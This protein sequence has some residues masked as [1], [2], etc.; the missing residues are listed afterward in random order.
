MLNYPN[1][2]FGEAKGAWT[3]P[4]YSAREKRLVDIF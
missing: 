1:V 3:M 4:N 2:E